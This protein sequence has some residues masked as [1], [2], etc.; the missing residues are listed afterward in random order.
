MYSSTHTKLDILKP[1]TERSVSSIFRRDFPVG[2]PHSIQLSVR[3]DETVTINAI[4]RFLITITQGNSFICM[5][6][7]PGPLFMRGGDFAITA[8]IFPIVILPANLMGR[9]EIWDSKE[10]LIYSW[11]PLT[12][13]LANT[14]LSSSSKSIPVTFQAQNGYQAIDKVNSKTLISSLRCGYCHT[15][16]T[17]IVPCSLNPDGQCG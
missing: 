10:R 3:M 4:G 9:L 13:M 7:S 17:P 8:R 1:S 15:Y 5:D 11:R 2:A 12:Q 14:I 16:S 6:I